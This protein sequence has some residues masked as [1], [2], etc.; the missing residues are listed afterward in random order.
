VYALLEVARRIVVLNRT[1]EKARAL[2]RE[3]RKKT[4]KEIEI[5][6]LSR[7]N[8]AKAVARAD[9]L[10]NATS[11]GMTAQTLPIETKDLRKELTVFDMV[12]GRSET[13]LQRQ[14]RESGCKT[15]NG[16]EMLLYQGA[17]AFEIWTGLKP[18]LDV[19]RKALA[20]AMV[21]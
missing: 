5:N 6:S 18:P 17:R 9:V 21:G 15:I 14:A 20:N 13:V 7:G 12:Y 8:L 16:I 10:V 1:V 19:M 2:R 11:A 3:I 4:S